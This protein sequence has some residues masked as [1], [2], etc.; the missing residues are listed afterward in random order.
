MTHSD[1]P[2]VGTSYQIKIKEQLDESWTEWFGDFELTYRTDEQGKTNTILTGMIIDQAA[3]NGLLTK[4]W[5]LSL[6][7]LSVQ[8]ID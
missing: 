3:L 7:V 1:Q 8:R 4:I 5:N 2:N 6:T